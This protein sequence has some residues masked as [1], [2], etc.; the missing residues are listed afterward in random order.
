MIAPPWAGSE[1]DQDLSHLIWEPSRSSGSS[2]A[3]GASEVPVAPEAGYHGRRSSFRIQNRALQANEIEELTQSDSSS[4][5]T[6]SSRSFRSSASLT[7]ENRNVPSEAPHLNARDRPSGSRDR[8]LMA[9]HVVYSSQSET[10]SGD[11]G[12][13]C[14][15]RRFRMKAL[16]LGSNSGSEAAAANSAANVSHANDGTRGITRGVAGS[17]EPSNGMADL[18]SVP[19]DEDGNLTSVGSILHHTGGCKPCLSVFTN[20]ACEFNI[21]CEFCHFPHKK[22]GK[23]RPC[24]KKRDRYRKLCD[25]MGQPVEDGDGATRDGED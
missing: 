8:P 25:H 12:S 23:T 3:Y 11:S 6:W 20:E 7:A 17:S 21:D 14:Q 1:D 9:G 18:A 13:D 2:N 4:K 15:P 22:K 5:T 24:K 16:S 10:V 19:L